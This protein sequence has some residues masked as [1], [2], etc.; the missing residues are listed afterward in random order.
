METQVLMPQLGESVTEGTIAKWLIKPG[1]TVKKY[2]PLCEVT[3]DKVNAEVPSTVEGTVTELVAREGDTLAVGELI[4][5]IETRV[6]GAKAATAQPADMKETASETPAAESPKTNVA[7]ASKDNVVNS[8]AK[9]AGK[10]YS[11]AVMR[12]AQE[13]NIDVTQIEGTGREGRITRKDVLAFI[14]NG[15]MTARP[16]ERLEPINQAEASTNVVN[17]ES[18]PTPSVRP[19]VSTPEIN[20]YPGD[21]EIPVTAIRKTIAS[22]MVQSKHDAPHAWTMVEVDMTNLVKLRNSLKAEFKAK[23][24][25]NL[26]FMPFFIKAVVESIKEFPIMNSVWAGDKIVMRK[27][28]NIS[29][30]VATD[31]ALFVPVIKDADQKSIYGLAH[32]VDEL[33]AKTRQGKLSMDD[34]S[35]GTFTVN[36]TGSFGSVLSAPIINQPQAAIVSMESIVKRPVVID[37]MI[38]IR[39]MANLCLS[40]DHRVLDGLVCGRFLQSVKQKLEA[41]G[42]HTTI[43]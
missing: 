13:N 25:F 18:V 17:M 12:L 6:G 11:P 31:D 39:D 23:E 41:Y 3:T 22:R 37:D 4:C 34:M 36:N 8:T 40:L 2:E 1:D 30:A 21:T 27:N 29:I 24:G 14:E 9:A 16:A 20:A 42:S 28:I 15:G 33:A 35:G 5:Y 7:L 38:A 10:R 19:A 26:T 32:A 43:Y